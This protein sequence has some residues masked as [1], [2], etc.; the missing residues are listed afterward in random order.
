MTVDCTGE[1]EPSGWSQG[2]RAPAAAEVGLCFTWIR[3]APRAVVPFGHSQFHGVAARVGIA[4]VLSKSQVLFQEC[5]V[6]IHL[7]ETGFAIKL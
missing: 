5:G 7:N 1:I 2:I 4:H 6:V 3:L